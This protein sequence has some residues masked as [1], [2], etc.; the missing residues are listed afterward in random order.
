MGS[1]AIVQPWELGSEPTLT[2][3]HPQ[4]N[5]LGPVF[6]TIP[7]G[8]WEQKVSLTSEFFL[9]LKNIL[10]ASGYPGSC[11]R[12]AGESV[13]SLKVGWWFSPDRWE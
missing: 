2:T 12:G 7:K 4:P 9:D 11:L 1:L 5:L 13:G 3:H 6:R 8:C 10:T